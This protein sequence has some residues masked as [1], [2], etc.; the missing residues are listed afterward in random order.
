MKRDGKRNMNDANREFLKAKMETEYWFNQAFRC[1]TYGKDGTNATHKYNLALGYLQT[2]PEYKSLVKQEKEENK[3]P[4][5]FFKYEIQRENVKMKW[6]YKGAI[7]GDTRFVKR[8]LFFPVR[9]KGEMHWLEIAYLYQFWNH[10][11]ENRGFV[12]E[13]KYE[14]FKQR[15]ESKREYI[16]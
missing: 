1:F 10:G 11:W 2:F 3:S 12:T 15:E 5:P 13:K 9:I 16:K 14:E 8:F 7:Y 6:I 4:A